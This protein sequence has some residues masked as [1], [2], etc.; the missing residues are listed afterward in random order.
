MLTSAGIGSGLD[1]D[2]LVGNLVS[3]E[4]APTT[5]RLNALETGYQTNLSGLGQFSSALASFQSALDG[6]N[7]LD[8]FQS[9][10][11]SLNKSEYVEVS[12]TSKAPL[13]GIDVIV[14]NL[15]KVQKLQSVDF[16]GPTD[17]VGSGE[18]T[19][20]AGT[21]I[22]P[23]S[24]DSNADTLADVRD[25]INSAA[26]G[27]GIQAVIVNVDDGAGGTVS[28]LQMTT[29]DTGV[30]ASISIFA[31]D[32]DGNDTDTSGLSRLAFDTG[33][34]TTN[35][36][37]T[38]AAEDAKI[39]ID[40]QTVTRSTN[41]IDDAI[42]GVTFTLLDEDVLETTRV[43]IDLDEA[44][45]KAQVQAFTGAYNNMID[46][47][48]GLLQVNVETQQV[49][50]LQGDSTVKGF[51]RLLRENLLT[52][53]ADTVSIANI[54]QLGINSDP[55]TGHLSVDADTL[56][57]AADL[58]IQDIGQFFAGKDG[59]AK[60][61]STVIDDFI[62]D[63]GSINQRT[64]SIQ[65]GINDID[66]QRDRLDLRLANLDERLRRDFIAMD[67][68][69]GQLNAVSGFLTQQLANLPGSTFE[70]GKN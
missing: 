62:G 48:K 66:D 65:A 33:T 47:V 38:Q 11:T 61:L 7:N 8:N 46:V 4:A 28:R 55:Q 63:D 12:T 49:G 30:A 14:E 15:A 45:A 26:S 56:D 69:V 24:I 18:L 44:S 39:Q 36:T 5:N 51:E 19:I 50:L 9:R 68:L 10:T 3:A 42:D 6:L 23:V 31:N 43:T 64:E 27:K 59:L 53:S 67:I 22:I 70:P 1:I 25:A 2:G 35:M 21:T 41:T 58:N 34:G 37:E 29:T 16:A 13:G 20:I 17:P 54:T 40:G 32:S 52:D 57:T 60:R